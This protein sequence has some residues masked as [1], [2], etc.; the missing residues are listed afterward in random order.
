MN[1]L[2]YF[3]H[4]DVIELGYGPRDKYVA[5]PG[6]GSGGF[7]NFHFGVIKSKELSLESIMAAVYMRETSLAKPD[8][9]LNKES[10]GE[11]WRGNIYMTAPD[12][13]LTD[14]KFYDIAVNN[15]TIND[16]RE[17][18][19]RLGTN[20]EG[21]NPILQDIAL[22]FINGPRDEHLFRYTVRMMSI[23]EDLSYLKYTN[24]G[25]KQMNMVQSKMLLNMDY[26]HIF[27][28]QGQKKPKHD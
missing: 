6:S 28:P 2:T 18:E 1:K 27:R 19:R 22:V 10:D 7:Y 15:V 24:F 25:R 13:N 20:L 5:G 16:I 23:F 17:E 21:V 3:N 8:I 4:D 11:I 14:P 26:D 12:F 9:H